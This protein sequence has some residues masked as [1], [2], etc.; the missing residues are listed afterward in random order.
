[1]VY[2]TE[3]GLQELHPGLHN[4]V[5]IADLQ[6]KGGGRVTQPRSGEVAESGSESQSG[7]SCAIKGKRDH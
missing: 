7:A 1:M 3:P 5:A 2:V 6:S 4:I